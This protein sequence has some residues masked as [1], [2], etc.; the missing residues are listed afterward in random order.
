VASRSLPWIDGKKSL[1]KQPS[2]VREGESNSSGTAPSDRDVIVDPV[3]QTISVAG[4]RKTMRSWIVCRY[5]CAYRLWHNALSGLEPP[6]GKSW[7]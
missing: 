2:A 6:A 1:W 4:G 5:Q 7:P 3:I